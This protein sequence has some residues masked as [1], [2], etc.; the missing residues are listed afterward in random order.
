MIW[1]SIFGLDAAAGKKYS[2][3][4]AAALL[5]GSTRMTYSIA[6]LVMETT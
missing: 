3:F 6:V 2:V 4:G 5:S 1:A